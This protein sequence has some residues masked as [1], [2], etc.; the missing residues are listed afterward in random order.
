M[1]QPPSAGNWIK[2]TDFSKIQSTIDIPDLVEVQKRSYE[3]F[4]QTE[5]ELDSERRAEKGLQAAL[6]SVFPI[7]RLTIV[8][9]FLNFQVIRWARPSTTCGSVWSRA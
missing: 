3:E 7:C 8:R 1:S 2:R 4:L 5:A 9:P 6:M